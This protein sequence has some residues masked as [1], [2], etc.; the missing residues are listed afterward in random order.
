LGKLAKVEAGSPKFRA[1]T[2]GGVL[3]SQSLI[4][5]VPNSEK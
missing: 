1:N 5:K 2:S 3:P 4:E